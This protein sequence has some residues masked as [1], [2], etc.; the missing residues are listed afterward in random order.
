MKPTGPTQEPKKLGWTAV[1]IIA[2]IVVFVGLCL[3]GLFLHSISYPPADTMQWLACFGIGAIAV[4][5]LMVILHGMHETRATRRF[6]AEVLRDRLPM[7][8]EE[9]GRRYYSPDLAP[10]AAR[11]R[12]LLA[13][14]L[15]FPPFYGPCVLESGPFHF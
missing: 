7:S 4:V 15:S 6:V 1:V 11:L 9:F 2:A 10:L 14:T 13:E 8:D 5:V 12:C 3:L